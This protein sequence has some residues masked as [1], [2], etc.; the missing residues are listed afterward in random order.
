MET[1]RRQ[2]A[3]RWKPNQGLNV[4]LVRISKHLTQEALAYELGVSQSKVSA[5]ELQD[6]INYHM[7]CQLARALEVPVDFLKIFIMEEFIAGFTHAGNI[8]DVTEENSN[9]ILVRQ[10]ETD[11]ETKD[12]KL[13]INKLSE[14]YSMLLEEK[15]KQISLLEEQIND[16]Q[17]QQEDLRAALL[18]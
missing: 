16:M 18:K 17:K 15:D 3:C 5:L 7:L 9:E 12:D 4:K 13:A 14:L 11:S 1:K 6:E 2:Y 10:E 8:I